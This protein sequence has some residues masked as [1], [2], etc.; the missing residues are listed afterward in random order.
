MDPSDLKKISN[1]DPNLDPIRYLAN[2]VDF[3][4]AAKARQFTLGDPRNSY[5]RRVY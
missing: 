3:T 2:L 1:P 5:Q 4:K